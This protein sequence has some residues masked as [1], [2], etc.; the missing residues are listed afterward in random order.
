MLAIEPTNQLVLFKPRSSPR[1]F[2]CA[3]DQ[4]QW[5]TVLR[6]YIERGWR[7]IIKRAKVLRLENHEAVRSQSW[8]SC[9]S[10]VG[11]KGRAVFLV[12]RKPVTG[13]AIHSARF[14]SET[15]T[16]LFSQLF[17]FVCSHHMIASSSTA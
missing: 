1:Y 7:L 5:R 11:Y 17:A 4:D 2:T 12:Q 16:K 10:E 14:R 9:E 3:F 15:A 6:P 8:H 13:S